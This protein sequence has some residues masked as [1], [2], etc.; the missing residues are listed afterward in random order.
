MNSPF[1][2]PSYH[3]AQGESLV[4]FRFFSFSFSFLVGLEFELRGIAFAK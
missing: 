1:P 3:R 4:L 2:S